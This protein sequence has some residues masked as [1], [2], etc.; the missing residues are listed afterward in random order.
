[1][2]V[3][4]LLSSNVKHISATG[5]AMAA[6]KGDGSVVTW[7]SHGSGGDSTGLED[8]LS[9]NV[10]RVFANDGAFAAVKADGSIIT[11]GLEEFG[12]FDMLAHPIGLSRRASCIH[13]ESDGH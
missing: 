2:E 8:L 6:V 3:M 13:V 7:G 5:G 1:M 9:S 12:G 10:L 4:E 11:W